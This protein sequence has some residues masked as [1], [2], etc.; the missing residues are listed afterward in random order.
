MRGEVV[1]VY[2]A[3]VG[4]VDDD[5]NQGIDIVCK[6]VAVAR[7][8]MRYDLVGRWIANEL[9]FLNGLEGDCE[10]GLSAALCAGPMH[11]PS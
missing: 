10:H 8:T 2:T 3:Q 5:G 9:A 6:G 1:E 7:Y 4:P 11:Y